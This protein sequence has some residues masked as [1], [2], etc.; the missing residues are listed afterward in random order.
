MSVTS[1]KRRGGAEE[2]DA[3]SVSRP[4][5]KERHE[6]EEK[7]ERSLSAMLA[8]LAPAI[9][10]NVHDEAMIELGASAEMFVEPLGKH[11]VQVLAC[12]LYMERQ[13]LP[14]GYADILKLTDRF[15]GKAMNITMVYRSI[16]RLIDRGLLCQNEV[17]DKG[18]NRS[19]TYTIHGAG[20][21]AFRL[22]VM[23]SQLLAEANSHVAA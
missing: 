11:E 1:F 19:R 12:A 9:T 17:V 10:T 14:L 18:G 6:L 13:D 15:T 21:E 4:P 3:G 22:A 23:N 2:H 16:E 8:L 7:A 20:R 5:T